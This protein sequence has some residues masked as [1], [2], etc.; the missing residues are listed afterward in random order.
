MEPDAVAHQHSPHARTPCV[1]CHIGPGS[2]AFLAAK[3][4]GLRQVYDVV[5]DRVPRPIPVPIHNLRPAT[6][7]C[8]VCHWPEQYYTPQYRRFVH[9][10]SDEA[11][12]RWEVHLRLMTGGGGPHLGG[13]GGIHAHHSGVNK[14]IEYVAADRE[15]N[16]IPWLRVTDRESGLVTEYLASGASRPDDAIAGGAVRPMDCIDCHNRPAHRYLDPDQSLNL[17]MMLDKI[18]PSLPSIKKIGLQV[19]SAHYETTEQ[20]VAAIADG[21]RAFYGAEHPEILDRRAP[22]VNAAVHHLQTIYRRNFFPRMK[23]RWDTYPDHSGHLATP[24]CFRCHDGG[25]EAASGEVV[26][27]DC[28]TCHAIVAQ[29]TAEEMAHATDE[30][31]LD[32]VHPGDVGDAWQGMA[33]T[34]CHG[35]GA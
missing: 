11:N 27:N 17:H 26:T 20:A 18:D 13:A 35:G 25:H 6:E 16:D 10:Q 28:R 8:Q 30:A 34:D 5:F 12:T 4:N 3:L 7:T 29:G 31:G 19:L 24:G 14:T 22:D 33:C 2:E 15:R 1:A 9:F 21:V 32:F 23:V